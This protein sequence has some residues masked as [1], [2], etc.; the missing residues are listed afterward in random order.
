MKYIMT[1]IKSCKECPHFKTANFYS[2]DGWDM[3]EDWVCKKAD[4]VI[5]GAVEWHEEKK[6][7]IPE[8]CPIQT[9]TLN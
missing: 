2:T 1:E 6:I 3:M 7:K 5:M 4:K 8:W 9:T